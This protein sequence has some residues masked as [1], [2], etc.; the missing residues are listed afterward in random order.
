VVARIDAPVP[1]QSHRPIVGAALVALKRV[2][3]RVLR[4]QL[5]VPLAR[6]AE[7]NR[8]LLVVLQELFD[9]LPPRDGGRSERP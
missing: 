6:Q 3:A 9:R 8:N 7:F 5:E 1:L 2:V 4:F